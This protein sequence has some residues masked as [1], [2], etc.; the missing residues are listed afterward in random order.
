M[1]NIKVL[2]KKYSKHILVSL[3]VITLIISG[4]VV[5][6]NDT[7]NTNVE[8][9]SEYNNNYITVY[10]SGE[11]NYPGKYTI[12]SNSNV[13]DLIQ[14]ANGLTNN[15]ETSYINLKKILVDQEQIHV[16]RKDINTNKQRININL[17]SLEEL[18]KLPGIGAEKASSII[19]YRTTY[20]SFNKIEDLL[21]VP[22][23]TSSILLNIKDE[24]KLS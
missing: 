10:I 3:V 9:V 15:A 17:A 14:Q 12:R 22:G 24:I 1:E 21:E 2:M 8:Y 16:P 5:N 7:N 20:G 18:M 23:I 13:L 11:V 19:L 4:I 6:A